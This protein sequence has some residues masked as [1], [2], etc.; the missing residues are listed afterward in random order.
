[1][2]LLVLYEIRYYEI[3]GRTGGQVVLVNEKPVE[4]LEV[5]EG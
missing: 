5:N 3:A 1:M 4:I 2:N